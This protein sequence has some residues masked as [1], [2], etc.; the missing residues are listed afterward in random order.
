[1]SKIS[2][3]LI[4]ILAVASLP[5]INNWLSHRSQTLN[6][7][8]IGERLDNYISKNFDRVL[9]LSRKSQLKI[10]MLMQPKIKFLSIK[11]KYSTPL[12][13]IQEMKIAMS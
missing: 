5:V 8:Y 4:F 1:M 11:M 2:F 13:L 3:L 10:V 6:D 9:K 12:I 7:D